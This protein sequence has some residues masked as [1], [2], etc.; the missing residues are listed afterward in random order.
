MADTVKQKTIDMF[1]EPFEKVFGKNN[2]SNVLVRQYMESLSDKA[3]DQL[4]ERAEKGDWAIPFY[5]PN[6]DKESVNKRDALKLAELTKT[7]IF[8]RIVLVDD[9]TG[10]ETLTPIKYPVLTLPIRRQIQHLE[11]KRSLAEDDKSVDHITG[12]VT[13]DSKASSLSLKSQASV[14]QPGVLAFG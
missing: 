4:M 9:E 6:F 14:V 5:S 10:E 1:M 2:K 7:V 8:E 13:G 12:Q 11:K 3:F